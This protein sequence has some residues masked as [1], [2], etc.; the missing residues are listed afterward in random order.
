MSPGKHASQHGLIPFG[1]TLDYVIHATFSRSLLDPFGIR[2]LFNIPE[3]DILLDC[4]VILNKI[5][6]NGANVPTEIL[7]IVLLQGN[8]LDENLS[9]RWLIETG[10]QLNQRGF[11]SPIVTNQRHTFTGT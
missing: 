10:E 8:I 11:T 6:K 9:F 4:H 3:A 7:Q 5:L 1:Q 2:D